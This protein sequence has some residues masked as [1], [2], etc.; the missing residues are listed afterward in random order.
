M[1]EGRNKPKHNFTS[2]VKQVAGEHFVNHDYKP[3]LLSGEIEAAR[4]NNVCMYVGPYIKDGTIS[5]ERTGTLLITNFRL[6]FV[7][8]EIED[9]Q[10]SFQSN[11]FLGSSDVSLSNID[12]IY[13]IVDKKKRLITPQ[14]KNSNKIFKIRIV[15][16]NFKTFTFGFQLSEIGKGK[17]IAD[18]LV[19]FAFPARHNLLFLYQF[20][21][22]YY[23]GT[24]CENTKMYNNKFD[25]LQELQRCGAGGWRVYSKDCRVSNSSLPMHF[26]VPKHLSDV[27]YD[28][29]SKSFRNNRSSIWVW[30]HKNASLV[31]LAELNPDITN[32]TVENILLEHVRRCDPQKRQPRLLELYKI[33]PSIQDV[34]LSYIKLRDLCTP[35]NDQQFMVQ[36]SRFYSMLEKSYWLLYVSLCLKHSDLAAKV[37]RDGQT[38]VLQEI[39]GRDM[40][41]VISSLVQLLLDKSFRTIYGF[42]NLIQKEWI[43]LG[44]PFS[45]RL[46]HV[47]AVKSTERSPLFLLFLDCVW[48]LLQQ[49]PT[50]FEFSETFLTTLWDSLFLPI[51]DTFQFNSE[52][53]RNHA[54]HAEHIVLRPVWDWA[55]QF[56]DKDLALFMN[57]L[58][59]QEEILGKSGRSIITSEPQHSTLF[60]SG[61]RIFNSNGHPNSQDGETVSLQFLQPQYCLRD[62]ELWQQC[63][64]RWIPHLQI[65]HGGIA[66][67]ELLNRILVHNIRKLS[68]MVKSEHSNEQYQSENFGEPIDALEQILS[69]MAVQTRD[70]ETTEPCLCISSFFPFTSILPSPQIECSELLITSNEINFS[71]DSMYETASLN[72]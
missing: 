27:E 63:Y 17:Y 13:H 11:R 38:V 72:D 57:P 32:T 26:V 25:W 7:S 40:C 29:I 28:N 71:H 15:C 37:L 41:G 60:T 12:R 31:R 56:D 64:F 58:Y 34:N 49:F 20:K 21:E 68:R 6:S 10:V 24:D 22:K 69:S 62:I 55:K 42:Q 23:K 14:L 33:L 39:N 16:K 53:E 5:G 30:G 36:D 65:K 52:T 2:Y 1:S 4:A 67:S 59:R 8:V 51:F 43:I 54:M 3:K 19:K 9:E 61:R 70:P 50:S 45:D 46:G 66:Q 48:Q 35:D 44:H 18:A 47:A